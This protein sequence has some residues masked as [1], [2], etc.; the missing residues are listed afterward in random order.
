M[1]SAA[2]T[3]RTKRYRKC[4]ATSRAVRDTPMAPAPRAARI[5]RTPSSIHET[6]NSGTTNSRVPI[7]TGATSARTPSRRITAKGYRWAFPARTRRRYPG[8]TDGSTSGEKFKRGVDKVRGGGRWL[9]GPGRGRL[10]YS[11]RPRPQRGSREP[12]GQAIAR[13]GRIGRPVRRTSDQV[14]AVRRSV[15]GAK[16][17]SPIQVPY[18]KVRGFFV[19][20][21]GCSASRALPGSAGRS[22]TS[23]TLAPLLARRLRLTGLLSGFSVGRV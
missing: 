22:R 6:R 19:G 13:E 4:V 20:R 5:D 10:L 12:G 1:R 18:R 21:S 9:V 23:S 14:P 16:R 15:G 3:R 2:F 7:A 11:G 17:E 8:R